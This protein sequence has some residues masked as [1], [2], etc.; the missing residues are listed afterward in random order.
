MEGRGPTGA[1]IDPGRRAPRAAPDN[2]RGRFSRVAAREAVRW[3]AK[4]AF[5]SAHGQ[6]AEGVSGGRRLLPLPLGI[7]GRIFFVLVSSRS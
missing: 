7:L 3:F 2:R 4:T 1:E 5:R 6:E